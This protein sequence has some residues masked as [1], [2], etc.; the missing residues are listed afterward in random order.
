VRRRRVAPAAL[1]LL[2]AL[3]LTACGQDGEPGA[4]PEEAQ[5]EPAALPA[6]P[7]TTTESDTGASAAAEAE[8]I[9]RAWSSALNAGDNEAA[10]DLFAP[11]AIVVQA[12]V[13]LRFADRADAVEWNAGLPCAGTIVDLEVQ[14]GVVI[15]VFA[16]D[17]RLT[18]ACDAAP[19]TLAAAAFVI[20]DGKI[21]MWQQI[22]PP[23]DVSPADTSPE[24]TAAAARQPR[25]VN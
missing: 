12:G 25:P 8:A 14:D 5:R 24:R 18:S 17:D 15:A 13:A 10:A 2:V 23:E 19:G 6:E 1:P 7:A 22:P 3:A 16:L 11:G 9:V 4:P 21:T 20:E